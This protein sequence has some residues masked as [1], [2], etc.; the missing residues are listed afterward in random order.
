MESAGRSK[1]ASSDLTR[2]ELL[3]VAAVTGG[4]LVGGDFMPGATPPA[5]AQGTAAV[6]TVL[7]VILR[8]NGTEHRLARDSRPTPRAALRQHLHLP[9]SKTACGLGPCGRRSVLTDG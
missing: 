9:G 4:A 1:V 5:N 3:A 2:R 6:S 7:D 8:V